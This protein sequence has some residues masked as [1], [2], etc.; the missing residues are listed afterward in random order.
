MKT[1]VYTRH[2][3]CRGLYTRE[4][5]SQSVCSDISA[6]PVFIFVMIWIVLVL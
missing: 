4:F 3:A 6:A 2:C 5:V 1:K